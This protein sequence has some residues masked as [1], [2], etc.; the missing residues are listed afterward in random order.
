IPLSGGAPTPL[1]A[2]P[3][4]VFGYEWSPDAQ[5]IAYLTRDPM[6]ADEERQRQDK[7]FVMRAD[8]PDRPA[9]LVVQQIAEPGSDRGGA[10]SDP[11][12]APAATTVTPPT[13]YVDGFSWSPDGRE[14]A[15]SAAP[16]S[17]FSA[18]Y[19]DRLYAIALDGDRRLTPGPPRTIVDR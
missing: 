12:R 17:G 9:R 11:A 10:A 7:S 15:Y 8:A 18:P 1:T 13:H 16:R 4:G 14:I 6:P 19:E 5:S 3:E 2:A